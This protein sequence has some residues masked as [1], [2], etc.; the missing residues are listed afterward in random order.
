MCQTWDRRGVG[1]E[2]GLAG[3]LELVEIRDVGPCGEWDT[4][5]GN[6]DLTGGSSELQ[7][8]V[9]QAEGLQEERKLGGAEPEGEAELAGW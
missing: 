1:R 7:V 5:V 8:G 6:K 2:Q 4:E 3:G 9:I